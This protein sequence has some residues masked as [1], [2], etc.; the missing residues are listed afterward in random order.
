MYPNIL[1]DWADWPNSTVGYLGLFLVAFSAQILSL[2]HFL[3]KKIKLRA[4]EIDIQTMTTSYETGKS[5]NLSFGFLRIL[6]EYLFG[7]G[8]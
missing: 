6:K 5:N 7:F 3:Y 1:A 8:L 2:C 4:F